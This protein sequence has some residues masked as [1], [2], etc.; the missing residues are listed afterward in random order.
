MAKVS[1]LKNY[2]ICDFF[3]PNHIF[4]LAIFRYTCVYKRMKNEKSGKNYNAEVLEK[5]NSL[6][7]HVVFA[8]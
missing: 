8:L 5:H 1:Q 3:D 6:S 4:H 7:N 2:P